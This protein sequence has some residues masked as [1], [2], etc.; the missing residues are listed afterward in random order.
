MID[1]L[2]TTL[3]AVGLLI[4]IALTVLVTATWFLTHMTRQAAAKTIGRK[5]THQ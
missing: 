1:A 5:K 2:V 4:A 3:A